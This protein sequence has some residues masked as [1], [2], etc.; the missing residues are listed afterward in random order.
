MARTRVRFTLNDDGWVALRRDD[1][2]KAMCTRLA[3]ACCDRCNTEIGNLRGPAPT[4]QRN[5]DFTVT[6]EWGQASSA[7]SVV[8]SS[9]RAT[10]YAM[11]TGC[12]YRNL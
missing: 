8:A 9:A 2:Y 4:L 6:D 5:E 3:E 10:Q 11:D 1:Q 12:M 7:I